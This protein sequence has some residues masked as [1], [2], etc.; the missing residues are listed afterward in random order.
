MSKAQK[1][2]K[3]S[4]NDYYF[5]GP[6]PREV[7]DYM[8]SCRDRGMTN[9]N[10]ARKLAYLWMNLSPEKQNQ[11][12]FSMIDADFDPGEKSLLDFLK[13]VDDVLFEVLLGFLPKS[14]KLSAFAAELQGRRPAQQRKAY[15]RKQVPQ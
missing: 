3:P 14:E 5:G 13:M 15:P 6:V 8:N 1:K 9:Q 4:K 10:I 11:L 12:Y 7:Q 2:I